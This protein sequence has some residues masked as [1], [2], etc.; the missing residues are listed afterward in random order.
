MLLYS[1]FMMF[2]IFR[3]Q[4]QWSYEI[5][6]TFFLVEMAFFLP[7]PTKTRLILTDQL[8]MILF[9][10]FSFYSLRVCNPTLLSKATVTSKT[11]IVPKVFIFR[12]P[13]W[14]CLKAYNLPFVHAKFQ[15]SGSSSLASTWFRVKMW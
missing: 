9:L 2:T 4:S 8:G 15:C 11:F 5:W 7:L 12:H 1:L 10:S 6:R 3:R 13:G 14:S